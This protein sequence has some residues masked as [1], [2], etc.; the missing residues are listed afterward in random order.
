MGNIQEQ[1]CSDFRYRNFIIPSKSTVARVKKPKLKIKPAKPTIDQNYDFTAY[2]A[3]AMECLERQREH[4]GKRT[5]DYLPRRNK[6]SSVELDCYKPMSLDQVMKASNMYRAATL[7]TESE[8]ND[9]LRE[10]RIESEGQPHFE[11]VETELA[12]GNDSLIE[13]PPNVGDQTST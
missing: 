12:I 10:I 7:A 2:A 5:I 8:R 11:I 4:R 6:L 13:L 9:E 3:Y 1:C